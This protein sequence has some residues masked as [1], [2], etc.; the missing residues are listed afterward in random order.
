MIAGL[1]QNTGS[2]SINKAP[3]LGDLPILGSLFRST[4][5]QRQET[6]LVVVVTPYLTRPVSGQLATPI[7]GYRTPNDIQRDLGGQTYEGVSHASPTAVAAPAVRAPG[8]A[9]PGFKM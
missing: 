2:N 9:A 8:T 5:F 6:E 1:I 4:K 7:D 3:L